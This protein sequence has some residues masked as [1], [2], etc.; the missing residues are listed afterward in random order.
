MDLLTSREEKSACCCTHQI[1]TNVEIPCKLIHC[2]INDAPSYMA[3]SYTWGPHQP[4]HQI[5]VN[6]KRFSVRSNLWHFLNGSWPGSETIQ[7]VAQRTRHGV[8]NLITPT[9]TNTS[10]G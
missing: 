8:L 5:L 10:F 7:K 9:H 4:A 2:P 1:S 6:E 3:L